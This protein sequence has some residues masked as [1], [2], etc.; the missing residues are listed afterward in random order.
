MWYA[1]NM[2]TGLVYKEK[3]K[4]EILGKGYKTKEK[5]KQGCYHLIGEY[6][7]GIKCREL[8]VYRNKELAIENGWDWALR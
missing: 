7:D 2:D 8:Y 6:E 1:F 4:Q 5:L 3:T